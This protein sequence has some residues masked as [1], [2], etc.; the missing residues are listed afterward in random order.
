MFQDA[1]NILGSPQGVD[2][3]RITQID[4]NKQWL[5]KTLSAGETVNWPL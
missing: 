1:V 3:E 4:S 2:N 5:L